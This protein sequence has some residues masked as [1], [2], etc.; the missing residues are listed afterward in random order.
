MRMTLSPDT[1][2]VELTDGS[3]V[4]VY[5]NPAGR[6]GWLEDVLIAFDDHDEQL[7]WDMTGTS[8]DNETANIRRAV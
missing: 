6:E 3:V 5:F 4:D 7:V 2:Q 1:T 8:L